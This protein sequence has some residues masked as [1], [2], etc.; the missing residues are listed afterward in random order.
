MTP[1]RRMAPMVGWLAALMVIGAA[2][3]AVGHGALAGPHLLTPSTWDEWA[4]SRP[5][6]D[7]AVAVVRL[8]VLALDGYLL[9]VT[10][11]AVGLR[12]VRAERAISVVDV[13]TVPLVLRVVQT[14]LGV[15]LVGA[16]VAA[17]TAGSSG[18]SPRP[19]RADTALVAG[20]EEPPLVRELPSRGE[21]TSTTTTSTTSTT[22]SSTSVPGVVTSDLPVPVPVPAVVAEPPI[23]LVQPGD[24]LWSIAE[25]TLATAWAR[26]VSDDEVAPYWRVLLERNRD[27]LADPSNPDLIFPGQSFVLPTP[28]P[29]VSLRSSP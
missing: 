16:S 22:T 9:V 8:V 24:H 27:R 15:G 19:T 13:L 28:P 6:P 29:V 5:A 14:G 7:A 23:W 3:V 21:P 20:A 12:L 4:A 17:A 18:F 2:M 25:R 10:V 26:S 11:V 1:G